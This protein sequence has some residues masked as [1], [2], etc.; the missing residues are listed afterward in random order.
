MLFR[1]GLEGR[2]SKYGRRVRGH[3][4]QRGGSWWGVGSFAYVNKKEKGFHVQTRTS[5]SRFVLDVDCRRSHRPS[6]VVMSMRA[7][8]PCCETSF[9]R[10]P[11]SRVLVCPVYV[12]CQ[13]VVFAVGKERERQRNVSL[14][15][16]Y[17]NHHHHCLGASPVLTI[18][19]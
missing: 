15:N 4:R 9:G 6:C 5:A 14:A 18:L 11:H 12:R 13:R 17:H 2:T 19:S 7:E 8:A 16:F 3:I 10:D 1:S